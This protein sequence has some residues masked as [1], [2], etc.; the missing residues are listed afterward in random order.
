MTGSEGLKKIK[1]I[2]VLGA[3]GSIG[4]QTLE[5]VAGDASLRACALAG[6]GNWKLLA[7]QA[8]QFQPDF[9][10]I[11][12]E[13]CADKLA[14]ALP[15]CTKLLAGP[16][17][18]VEMVNLS[19]PDMLLSGVVGSAG[20]APTL[21]AI[22]CGADLAIA[23]KETLV[24]AGG[25][26]MP[27]ARAKGIAVLPV[28]SEHS[29]IFQCLSAGRRSEVRRVVITASGG[30]LRDWNDDDAAGASV[31]D[32][33]NHP[34]WQM[35]R[36][37]TIDSA[38]LMNKALEIIEAHWLFDLPCEQIDVVVHPESIIHSYVEFCDG[39]VIA[40]LARPDMTMPIAY[41]LSYP[42]RPVRNIA[43]LD[44]A[45]L[46]KLTFRPLSKRFRRAVDLAYKVIRSGSLAGAVL[47]AANES[48]VEAFLD[49]KISLG[50][51]VPMVED[52][53]AGS[54][55]GLAVNLETLLTADRSARQ[56]VA[57]RLAIGQAHG[58]GKS[59]NP[60]GQQK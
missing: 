50:Q 39:S 49:E 24:M 45:A 29:A 43:P 21:A 13:S 40:Q 38:T 5:V 37:I 33:L 23:N 6:G 3:T 35:G 28:D 25:V 59:K 16:Q 2:A 48:A 52:V 20:L 46:G 36:K 44:L 14:G 11:T 42:D 54:P 8:R 9:V 15:A 10:A 56:E 31:A 12:D 19:R 1:R 34:T 57:A 58:K 22:D 53:L 17:A 47:N 51:I 27:A 41:A 60:S 7:L 18:M 55:T 4:R 26:V 32:A 30:A